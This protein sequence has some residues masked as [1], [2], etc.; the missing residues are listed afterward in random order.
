MLCICAS[1]C[2]KLWNY[3]GKQVPVPSLIEAHNTVE[4]TGK[5]SHEQIN[6]VC[7]MESCI[8]YSSL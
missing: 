8:C 3:S 4:E 1:L 6:E 2:I 5:Q 7:I